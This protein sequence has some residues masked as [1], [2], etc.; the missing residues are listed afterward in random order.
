[1]GL[2]LAMRDVFSLVTPFENIILD[3]HPV[4]DGAIY[5]CSEHAVVNGMVAADGSVLIASSSMPMGSEVVACIRSPAANRDWRLCDLWTNTTLG[6]LSVGHGD[7]AMC[8]HTAKE[9][10]SLLLFAVITPCG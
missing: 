1:M 7:A 10:G 5:N 6:V 9:T 8:W 4:A 2:W 3:G